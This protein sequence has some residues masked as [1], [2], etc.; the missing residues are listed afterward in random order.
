MPVP[1]LRR[2][3][4]DWRHGSFSVDQIERLRSFPDIGRDELIRFFTL[5]RA[6]LEFVDNRGRGRGLRPGWGWLCSC[7][8]CHG[9]GSFRRTCKGRRPAAAPAPGTTA[10][11]L[12][13]SRTAPTPTARRCPPR[14]ESRPGTA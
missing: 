10:A 1:V 5:T 8:R 4:R 3:W 12:W 2:G 14:P 6:D 13:R 9:W 11:H 7:A